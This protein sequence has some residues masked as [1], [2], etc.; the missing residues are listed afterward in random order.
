MDYPLMGIIIIV[1]IVVWRKN[2]IKTPDI[3][4][5]DNDDDPTGMDAVDEELRAILELTNKKLKKA[6]FKTLDPKEVGL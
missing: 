5:G 4:F 1:S 2:L 3:A 6:G